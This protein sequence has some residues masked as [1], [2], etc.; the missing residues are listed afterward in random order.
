[1][2]DPKQ[3]KDTY[4]STLRMI[5]LLVSGTFLVYSSVL[6]AKY[7][8]GEYKDRTILIL[9]TYPI[10][11]MQLILT[12][13][14]MACMFSCVSIFIGYIFCLIYICA[15]EKYF[16]VLA[17]NLTTRDLIYGITQ[18]AIACLLGGILT[19]IPYIVGMIKKSASITI[20]TA[21]L[22]VC[23]MQPVIGRTPT[24][25]S[26]ILKV[27]IVVALSAMGVYYTLKTKIHEVG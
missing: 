21:I 6:I 4:E 8:I 27:T 9:F 20:V 22:V 1:M 14:F 5:N 7:I 13:L 12:K 19:V 2:I 23:L 25:G 16:D 17:D 10:K 26:G 11:R 18:A 3:V 24:I 15:A